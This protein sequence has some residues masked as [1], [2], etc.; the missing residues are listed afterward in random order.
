MIPACN[1]QHEPSYVLHVLWH[2]MYRPYTPTHRA[3]VIST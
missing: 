3:A 1:H 2:D